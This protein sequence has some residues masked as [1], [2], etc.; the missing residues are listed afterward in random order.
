MMSNMVITPIRDVDK[1]KYKMILVL[2]CMYI[3]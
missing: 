1:N 3:I 2:D